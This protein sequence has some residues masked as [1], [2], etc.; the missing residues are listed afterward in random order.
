MY[1]NTY[2]T[3]KGIFQNIRQTFQHWRQTEF[4]FHSERKLVPH[5]LLIPFTSLRSYKECTLFLT[6][7]SKQFGRPTH[8]FTKSTWAHPCVVLFEL[9]GLIKNQCDKSQSIQLNK[10]TL[11]YAVTPFQNCSARQSSASWLNRVS[12]NKLSNKNI[13]NTY[14]FPNTLA[15]NW[16]W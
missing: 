15:S 1:I 12:V 13:K 5:A 7:P 4:C 6:S 3:A 8:F 2:T 11:Y 14:R 10:K 9:F 16:F